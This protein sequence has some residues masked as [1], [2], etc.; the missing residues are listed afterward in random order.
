MFALRF[1]SDLA[2]RAA[3]LSLVSNV[4]LMVLKLAVGVISG[5][6]AV[7]S[8]GIDSAQDVIAS[9]I[10]FISVRIGRRPPDPQHPYGHGRAETVAA[11][12]QATLITAGGAYILYRGIERLIS[13]VEQIDSTLALAA[14]AVTALVNYVVVLYVG[15]VARLTHSPAIAADAR[16]LWTN[17]VQAGAIFAALLLVEVTGILAFDAIVALVLGG[18]LLWIAALIYWS[19][20]GD[21]LDVSLKP[22]EIEFIESVIE[23]TGSEIEFHDLRTRRSGQIRYIDF[24]LAVPGEMTVADSH[25]IAEAIERAIK[26]RWPGAYVMVHVDPREPVKSGG[27]IA[28]EE[29]E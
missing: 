22:D 7:L 21:I 12:L 2:T 18:Y 8:D 3:L 15:R 19:S 14:I 29:A 6:V 28:I 24:H 16:H 4:C 27:A 5:S 17:I 10:V 9:G 26:R 20:I 1:T 25:E 11:I 23:S 13:P